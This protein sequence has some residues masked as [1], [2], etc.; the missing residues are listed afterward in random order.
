MPIKFTPENGVQ[1][2]I[3]SKCV[4]ELILLLF[5][6]SQIPAVECH[7]KKGHHIFNKYYQADSSHSGKGLGLGLAIY[8]RVVTLCHLGAISSG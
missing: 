5:S 2:N 3:N 4:R 7:M 8:Y 1:N 6:K